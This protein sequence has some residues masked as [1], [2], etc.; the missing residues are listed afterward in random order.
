MNDTTDA[1]EVLFEK[2]RDGVL[3]ITL[4]RPQR[5]N[6]FSNN[7]WELIAGA[8]S[9]AETDD[10]VRCVVYTG[11]PKVFAAG[12]D[13][14]QMKSRGM[15][16]KVAEERF[17]HW[18]VVHSFPKPVIAAVNGYALGGGCEFAM[19]A[20]I[21]IAGESARFGLPEVNLS[22]LAGLGGTQRLVRAVR[23]ITDPFSAPTLL[24]QTDELGFLALAPPLVCRQ[25]LSVMVNPPSLHLKESVRS[26][27]CDDPEIIVLEVRDFG[28]I[29]TVAPGERRL[30]ENLLANLDLVEQR[31]ND[32]VAAMLYTDLANR[33]G[34]FDSSLS[35]A[36]STLSY[37][38]FAQGT[39]FNALPLTHDQT[40]GVDV[41]SGAMVE[42][43]KSY[44]AQISVQKTGHTDYIT[45]STA[46]KAPLFPYLY[47]VD[48]SE[49]RISA[50]ALVSMFDGTSVA[51]FTAPSA[52]VSFMLK[53]AALSDNPGVRTI[54]YSEVV[55]RTRQT[56]LP[57]AT[58]A[59]RE[60]YVS[61]SKA[62]GYTYEPYFDP[63]QSR[64]VMT[65]GLKSAVQEFQERT[66]L[67]ANGVL[68][69]R[70]LNAL[71]GVTVLIGNR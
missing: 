55:A 33:V 42:H 12:S 37:F 43:T 66:G 53:E 19:V 4:N 59:E 69:Y 1:P 6:A 30:I 50:G 58:V 28:G 10:D 18:D 38:Y 44:Q 26:L 3:L 48:P 5:H 8:L 62:I 65:E 9:E 7:S 16:T 52:I 25:S 15:F 36:A 13:I 60:L 70:S 29:K 51:D 47:S 41:L 17:R 56:V 46:A 2:P 23:L 57:L 31:G 63:L 71:S 61:V 39:G 20:D 45:L 34:K 67:T 54:L 64:Y 27:K 32:L 49:D 40:K 24:G 11:G 35:S 21:I 68:D 22:L 14:T